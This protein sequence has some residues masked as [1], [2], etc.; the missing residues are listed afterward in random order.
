MLSR[1]IG[2]PSTGSLNFLPGVGEDGALLKLQQARSEANLH[3]G[4][5]SQSMDNLVAAETKE[6]QTLMHEEASNT[7]TLMH[8]AALNILPPIVVSMCSPTCAHI[9][10][11]WSF[12]CVNPAWRAG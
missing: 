6:L 10:P 8:R 4:K 11:G 3:G 12:I 9:H 2:A 7:T 1:P 5:G